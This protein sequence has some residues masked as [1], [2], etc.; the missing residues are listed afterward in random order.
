MARYRHNNIR[1]AN[2][3]VYRNYIDSLIRFIECFNLQASDF[4]PKR[5]SSADRNRISALHK[6]FKDSPD[7]KF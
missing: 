1:T 6:N 3:S 2:V 5:G 7:T 4:K